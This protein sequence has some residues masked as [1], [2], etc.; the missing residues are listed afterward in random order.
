MIRA[1]NASQPFFGGADANAN[2]YYSQVF[3]QHAIIQA[4]EL[5][6]C[7]LDLTLIF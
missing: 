7:E 6:Y 3:C 5:T 4:K 1:D 2:A